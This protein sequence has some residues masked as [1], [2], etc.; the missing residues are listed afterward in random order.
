MKP[1]HFCS[2]N[3]T[4]ALC[5]THVVPASMKPEH[6]C[7]GNLTGSPS[8]VLSRSSFNEA[9][10]FLLRKRPPCVVARHCSG[11]ASMKPEHFCSGNIRTVQELLGHKD[12][13]Q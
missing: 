12:M 7:S 3:L 13:L 6:F 10:A 8:R 9:G 1:E 11:R 2:G 4:Q 5:T